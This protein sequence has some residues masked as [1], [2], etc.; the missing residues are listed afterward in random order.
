MHWKKKKTMKVK[1]L[2]VMKRVN[3]N[4]SMKNICAATGPEALR[5]EEGNEEEEAER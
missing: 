4:S 1:M 3:F 2:M 5:D